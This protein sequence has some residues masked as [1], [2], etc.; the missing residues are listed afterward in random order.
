MQEVRVESLDGLEVRAGELR[1]SANAGRLRIVFPKQVWDHVLVS[2][3]TSE[4]PSAAE[5]EELHYLRERLRSHAQKQGFESALEGVGTGEPGLDYDLVLRPAGLLAVTTGYLFAPAVGQD[6]MT[7]LKTR[8]EADTFVEQAYAIR[9][10]AT[11]DALAAGDDNLKA[12]SV[13]GR[14]CS[15]SRFEMAHELWQV[16]YEELGWENVE[17]F[18]TDGGV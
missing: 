4:E 12:L 16:L 13:R 10:A 1:L 8:L 17:T 3:E 18:V 15:T 14:C 6:L 2:A 11:E 5:L 9:A 7:R